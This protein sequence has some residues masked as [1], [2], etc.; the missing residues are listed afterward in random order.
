MFRFPQAVAPAPTFNGRSHRRG[1]PPALATNTIF[2]PSGDSARETGSVVAGVVISRRISAGA[3]PGGVDGRKNY[4]C[5]NRD[6]SEHRQRRQPSRL[7][8]P[9]AAR[10]ILTGRTAFEQR[11]VAAL[12]QRDDDRLCSALCGVVQ[13]QPGTESRRFD[14]GDGIGPRVEPVAS[15]Q[16]LRPEGVVLQ[17]FR[18]AVEGLLDDEPKQ[19]ARPTGGSEDVALEDPLEVLRDRAWRNR[20]AFHR[21]EYGTRP[22][23]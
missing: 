5:R 14:P 6:E 12:R 3:G 17:P 7:R 19:R 13:L 1:E 2:S 11:N 15:S 16:G 4:G 9:A 22:R 21:R 23:S 8:S 10:S 20:R 18:V